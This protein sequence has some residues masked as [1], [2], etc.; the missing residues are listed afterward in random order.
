MLI[1]VFYNGVLLASGSWHA[2]PIGTASHRDD[3]AAP[4]QAAI[5]DILKPVAVLGENLRHCV[6]GVAWVRFQYDARA[7]LT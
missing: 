4:F 2:L 3:L 1:N 6:T 7:E 5:S